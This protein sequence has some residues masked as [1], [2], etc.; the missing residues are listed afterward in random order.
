LKLGKGRGFGIYLNACG[1]S[2]MVVVADNEFA[3]ERFMDIGFN[4]E[5]SAVAC[6]NECGVRVFGFYPGKTSVSYYES[7][8]LLN[9]RGV[10]NDAPF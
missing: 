6:G 1:A 3:V 2:E 7:L 8:F 9:F 4:T 5:V 10:H